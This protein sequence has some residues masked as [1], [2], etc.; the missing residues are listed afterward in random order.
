MKVPPVY[1]VKTPAARKQP[2]KNKTNF[3]TPG[4]RLSTGKIQKIHIFAKFVG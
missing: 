2:G 3:S 1:V 4:A